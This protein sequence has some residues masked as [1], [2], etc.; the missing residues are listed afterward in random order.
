MKTYTYGESFMCKKCGEEQ[1]IKEFYLVDK[2]TG[3]RS[4]SCRNCKIKMAGCI[5]VGKYRYAVKLFHK[6][7]RRCLECKIT[8]PLTDF[9]KNKSSF[10][11]YSNTCRDCST[12]VHC[13]FIDKKKFQEKIKS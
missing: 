2:D 7:F 1:P 8:K 12:K 5:E 9:C 11:G 13:D 4:T 3:R 10:G 6:G